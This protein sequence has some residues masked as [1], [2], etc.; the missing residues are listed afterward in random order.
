V[1]VPGKMK[2]TLSL[3]LVFLNRFFM[4][5]HNA[6]LRL[7]KAQIAILR[8]R[9]PTQRIILSPK[10][11]AELI[12]IG[13]ECGHDIDGLLE[14]AKAATYKR[15]L[16]QMRVG[17]PFKAVGRPRLTQE[18]RDVVIRIGSENLLWGYKRIAGELKKLGLYAG[19]NSVKRILIEVGIHPSPE[20]RT[21]KPALPWTTFIEA[22]ME[23][24]IACDF[25]SKTVLTLRGPRA[26]YVLMFIHLGSRR[27]FCSAPT[28]AP[29]AAWVT[30]QARNTLMW[31]AERGIRPGFLIRDADTK[32]GARFDTVWDSEAAR[33]IQI[34]HRA[35]D[36]NAFA[37]SFIATI[38]RECLDFFVC[39]NRSQLDYI[40]RT[41]VR[42]YNTERPHRGRGI[43][44]NVLQVDF[45]PARD[46]PIRRNRQLGGVITSYTRDA[47]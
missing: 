36:A 14:V 15:W 12:R 41:W 47:A 8:A 13:A 20:R 29:D 11:K 40:L 22:H 31:C 44:N 23:A 17:I 39:F 9:I 35:P 1:E 30:Q 18:L 5:R 28:Y 33:V 38:K 10:E 3:L 16:A 6:Q 4:P 32:F 25:F 7:L 37:E 21:K 45:R 43:G 24:M 19:T 2:S 46:G 34:P 42:H 26:A 27:V